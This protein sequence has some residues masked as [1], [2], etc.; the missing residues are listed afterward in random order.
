MCTACSTIQSPDRSRR[1]SQPPWPVIG[2]LLLVQV[3]RA[4]TSGPARPGG[5]ARPPRETAGS[6]A[7]GTRRGRPAPGACAATRDQPIAAGEG[8]R[9]RL[10][11]VEVLAGRDRVAIDRLVQVARQGDDDRVDVRRDRAACRGSSYASGRWPRA[12]STIPCPRCRCLGSASQTATIGVPGSSST[13]RSSA[14]PRLPMPITPSRTGAASPSTAA[15]SARLPCDSARLAAAEQPRNRRRF[16]LNRRHRA[17]L[18]RIAR[19]EHD[20]NPEAR[21]P[22]RQPPQLAAMRH[23]Y[24]TSIGSQVRVAGCRESGGHVILHSLGTAVQMNTTW[25]RTRWPSTFS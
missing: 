11:G 24:S 15:A 22:A 9:Q 18:H 16:K 12:F 8:E 2:P 6:T 4:S 25:T 7:A 23:S 5:S 20:P 13:L 19:L 17:K 10:L 14:V 3:A 21:I 1:P